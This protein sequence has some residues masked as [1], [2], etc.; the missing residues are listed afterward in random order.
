MLA[1]GALGLVGLGLLFWPELAAFD[2]SDRGVYGLLVCF[3]ATYLASLGNIV[4]ARNQQRKLPV[5]Q[6]NAYGMSYGALAM[7]LIAWASN[8]PLM[9]DTSRNYL[10]ALIYLALFGSV[11]AFGCYLT[12]IGRVGAGRAAYVTLLFPI[13]ALSISTMVEGYQWSPPALIGLLLIL[14]GNALAMIRPGLKTTY[15]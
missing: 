4:S 7:F 8:T 3:V 9:F 5:M 13:V 15:R 10:I 2:L 11:V 1:G 14:S 12:L 6:T